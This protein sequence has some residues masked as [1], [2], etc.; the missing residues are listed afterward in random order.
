MHHKFPQSSTALRV[1]VLILTSLSCAGAAM[2]QEKAT[3][4]EPSAQSQTIGT[5]GNSAAGETGSVPIHPASPKSTAEI[6]RTSL[7]PATKSNDPVVT[8]S[9]PESKSNGS[10]PTTSTPA[11]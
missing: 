2:A 5:V 6:R 8:A 11:T 4:I 7:T 1:F 3:N 10:T 9:T